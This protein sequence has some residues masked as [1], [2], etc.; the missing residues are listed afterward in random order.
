MQFRRPEKAPSSLSG[1][2]PLT[3]QTGFS[4][5]NATFRHGRGNHPVGAL[6]RH[7]FG[8]TVPRAALG[9]VD[10]PSGDAGDGHPP[11]RQQRPELIRRSCRLLSATQTESDQKSQNAF[12]HQILPS[13]TDCRRQNRWRPAPMLHSSSASGAQ[14]PTISRHTRE[15]RAEQVPPSVPFGSGP[16]P[17]SRDLHPRPKSCF[18]RSPLGFASLR[19]KWENVETR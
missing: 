13:A 1:R 3:A 16:D 7:P 2:L 14:D 12:G 11:S 10:V 8:P 9:S 19:G 6:H 4:P 17:C 18:R 15:D 5:G